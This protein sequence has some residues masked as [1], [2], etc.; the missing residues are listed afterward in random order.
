MGHRPGGGRGPAGQPRCRRLSVLVQRSLPAVEAAIDAALAD[1]PEGSRPVLL[2]EIA[3]LARYD[4][5]AM[6]SRWADLGMAAR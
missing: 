3:P 6:L 2:T 4:H 5:L 1:V